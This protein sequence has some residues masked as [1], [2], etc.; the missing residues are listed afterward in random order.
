MYK[1]IVSQQ[2]NLQFIA[3][4]KSCLEAQRAKTN[5]ACQPLSAE[6]SIILPAILHNYYYYDDSNSRF[7]FQL[8]GQQYQALL[9]RGSPK[10]PTKL[11]RYYHC[12]H[13]NPSGR[14]SAVTI[15]VTI[16]R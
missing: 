12:I 7:F 13:L 5:R 4:I 11:Q 8:Q 3:G 10:L 16:L 6:R 2:H 14:G 1:C 15:R 9:I